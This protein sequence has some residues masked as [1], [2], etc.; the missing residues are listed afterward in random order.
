MTLGHVLCELIE[1]ELTLLPRNTAGRL[2]VLILSFSAAPKVLRN[3][4]PLIGRTVWRP[5]R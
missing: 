4:A 5:D 1:E 3:T 2:I